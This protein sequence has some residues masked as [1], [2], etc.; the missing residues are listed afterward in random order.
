MLLCIVRINLGRGAEGCKSIRILE[1]RLKGRKRGVIEVKGPVGFKICE[2]R[3]GP[4]IRWR[5]ESAFEHVDHLRL[6]VIQRQKFEILKD[7]KRLM[8][9]AQD[10]EHFHHLWQQFWMAA[11]VGAAKHLL[12]RVLACTKT[13]EFHA[14]PKARARQIAMDGA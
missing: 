6:R 8:Q 7:F 9:A 1:G 2:A 13:V 3:Q 11:P 4:A 12:D 5:G 14:A 10:A